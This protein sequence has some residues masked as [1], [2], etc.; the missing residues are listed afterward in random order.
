MKKV[1]MFLFV[2]LVVLLAYNAVYPK[3]IL[4]QQT[5]EFTVLSKT[6]PKHVVVDLKDNNG[7]EYQRVY[8][9]KYCY[10][11]DNIKIGEKVN[12]DVIEYERD[13]KKWKEVQ[14]YPLCQN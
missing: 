10:T 6:R 8:V 4:S 13:N 12:L 3:K 1:V 7:Q 9:S 5:Q 2:Y 14:A 11:W